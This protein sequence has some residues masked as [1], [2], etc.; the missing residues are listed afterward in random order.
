MRRTSA[1]PTHIRSRA[2]AVTAGCLS[3]AFLLVP[4][5]ATAT[6]APTATP[7]DEQGPFYATNPEG[8]F[9][10]AAAITPDGEAS[11]WTSDMVIAQGVANDDPRIFRG[12]HEGPVYDLYSLSAAWDESNVYL[13][14]QF[15]NVTD[16]TD[17]AQSYPTSD[18]GKP[19]AGDLPQSIAL[20][21]DPGVGTDGLIDGTTDGVWGIHSTYGAGQ[22]VDHLAMFSSK[23]GVGKPSLFTLNSAGSFDYQAA[24]VHGFEDAG[25]KF[26]H[27]D[28]LTTKTVT[29]IN[30]T[31]NAGYLP[32]DLADKALYE[33]L[34]AAGHDSEQDTTYEM[35]IPLESLGLSRADLEAKGIGVML[36]TTFGE[37]AINSLPQDPAVLDHATDP[38]S[39]DTSTSAEKEDDDALSVPLARIGHS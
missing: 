15:T 23:P 25:I 8:Q 26:A 21:V 36:T 29:G 19:Y 38:Y 31:G 10:K 27:A 37:S 2:A 1:A 33:D 22:G 9:G 11:E 3:V 32:A 34:V 4:G 7:Q 24:N 6:G 12:S 20:D 17:P 18:N 14:W 13:M 5:Y 28:G 30:A 39:A 35:K 16:V